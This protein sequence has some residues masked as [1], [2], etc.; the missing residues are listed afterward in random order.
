MIY[1]YVLVALV[2]GGLWL[3]FTA[4]V[5]E[6]RHVAYIIVFKDEE[7]TV[8]YPILVASIGMLITLMSLVEIM[9]MVING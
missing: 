3:V 8:K 4:I 5:K 9:R 6:I 2:F 7:Y 1:G